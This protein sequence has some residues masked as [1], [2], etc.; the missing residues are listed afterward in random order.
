MTNLGVWNFPYG[1]MKAVFA[2]LTV[3]WKQKPRCM[4]IMN[5]PKT[6]TAVFTVISQFLD[7][8][9]LSKISINSGSHN[10]RLLELIAPEQLEE[11]Y[12]GLAPNKTE[13]FWPPSYPSHVFNP[14][15]PDEV[16]G[17]DPDGENL[18]QE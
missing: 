5:A 15:P 7:E 3:Q 2:V 12:G 14:M 4:F 11:R 16:M 1:I 10:P 9:A 8:N 17:E 18:P 6:F 13:N